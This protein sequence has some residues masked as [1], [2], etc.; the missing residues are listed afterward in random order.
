MQQQ[1]ITDILTFLK[2]SKSLES[3]MRYNASLRTQKNTVAEHSWRLALMALVIG[4]ACKVKVDIGKAMSMALLHDLAEATTGDID[5]YTQIKEGKELVEEK[6]VLEERAVKDMTKDLSF[7]DQVYDLWR[8]YEDQQTIEAKFVDALDVIE[9][10]LHIAEDGVEAYIPKEF[11]ASYADKAVAAFDKAAN[12]F[13]ELN[14]LLDA[15]KKDLHAQ[16]QKVGVEWV[17]SA[18]ETSSAIK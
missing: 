16:F 12:H 4:S 6:N 9:G 10:F 2:R 1:E 3:A 14:D 17:D 18:A 11:H 7:G 5:A 15:V 13:P 8:E